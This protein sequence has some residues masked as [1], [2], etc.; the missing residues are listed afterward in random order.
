MKTKR[1][2]AKEALHYLIGI[3]HTNLEEL[4]EHNDACN[5]FVYGEKVA[6][7][8]CLEVLQLWEFA[9]N[10]GLDYEIERRF[11]LV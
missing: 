10:Y 8:E 3:I 1:L 2:S 7:V 6:Y 9:E 11:P 5:Q 4:G